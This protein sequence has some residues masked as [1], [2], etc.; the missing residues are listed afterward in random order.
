MTG[1][2]ASIHREGLK[3][4]RLLMVLSSVSPLF[5]LWAI[6][7]NSL[8]PDHRFIG[9]CTLMVIVP[10]A[11]LWLRIRTARKQAD[12]RELAV[13]T[14][15]RAARYLA[16][17]RGQ[18]ETKSIDKTLLKLLYK[19]TDLEITESKGNVVITGDHE[20]GFLDVLDRRRYAVRLVKEKP[21]QYRAASRRKING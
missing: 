17:I 18:E 2:P 10:N 4:A 15:P 11:C 19:Q 1:R 9:F 8:I 5:F 16:S 20:M 6:R 3:D 7:G 12:K 21:E 13:G 14:H